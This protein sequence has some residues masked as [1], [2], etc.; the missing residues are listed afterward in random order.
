MVVVQVVVRGLSWRP[1][2]LVVIGAL[3]STQ[4]PGS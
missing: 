1:T 2:S 3:A 4:K